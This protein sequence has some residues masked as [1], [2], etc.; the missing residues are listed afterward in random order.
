MFYESHIE[1]EKADYLVQGKISFP[2]ISINATVEAFKFTK[3]QRREHKIRKPTATEPAQRR[4]HE[5]CSHA[6]HMPNNRVLKQ[7][8]V[9]NFPVGVR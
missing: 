8:T 7:A 9:D 3:I 5:A 1:M 6:R 2:Q 4:A